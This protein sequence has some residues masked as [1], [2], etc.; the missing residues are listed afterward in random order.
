[1]I[2]IVFIKLKKVSKLIMKMMVKKNIF[3]NGIEN[4]I[5]QILQIY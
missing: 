5:E 4:R 2:I 3:I 1:M